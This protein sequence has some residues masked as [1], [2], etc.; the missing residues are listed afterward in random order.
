MLYEHIKFRGHRAYED[1]LFLISLVSDIFT[2]NSKLKTT[3]KIAI[4]EGVAV[5][6]ANILILDESEQKLAVTKAVTFFS[7]E[8][9]VEI[10]R[11]A[12]AVRTL[13]LGIGLPE[14]TFQGLSED[15]ATPPLQTYSSPILNSPQPAPTQM[16]TGNSIVRF[17]RY[18]WRVLERRN[19]QA[20]LLCDKIVEEHWYHS[21]Y[22]P[23]T[24]EG[25]ALRRYLNGEFYN[26]NFS[27]NEKSRISERIV[28][29]SNN[30]W[31]GTNG[32]GNTNDR[33]FL[34]SIEEVVR[35]FGDSG[36]FAQ[37]KGFITDEYNQARIAKDDQGSA[38]WWWLRSPGHNS[39]RAAAVLVDGSVIVS[40]LRVGSAAGVVRPA[41]WLNL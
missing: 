38:S 35:Y 29:N 13:G 18:D 1:K 21:E 40:G 39:R 16:T 14:S 20:L 23:I 9:G 6:L 32:G 36:Q 22:V 11:A 25:C 15:T 31:Y 12:E 26:K 34:L 24:W 19:G 28:I 7:E 8:S 41:L 37:G 2:D 27:D 4:N 33:I 5:K 10:V 30:P 17:G 3:L